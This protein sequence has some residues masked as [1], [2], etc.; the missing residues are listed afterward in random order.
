M[1]PQD[2]EAVISSLSDA[3]LACTGIDPEEM[4][5]APIGSTEEPTPA[6]VEE[7]AKLIGC[8]DD[9]TVNQFY[10]AAIVPC[11]GPLSMEAT[12]CILAGLEVIDPRALMTAGLVEDEPEKAAF[13]NM[14][15]SNVSIACLTDEDWERVGPASGMSDLDRAVGQCLMTELGGPGEYAETLIRT[16]QESDITKLVRAGEE[17]RVIISVPWQPPATPTPMPTATL[18]ATTPTPKPAIVAS[19]PTPPPPRHTST[20]TLPETNT[21]EITVAAI[22]EWL[23]EYDR[24]AIA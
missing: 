1:P 13:G 23:P 21:L 22:P 7:M 8:L 14:A 11:P 15:A 24:R 16:T 6:D 18:W 17:C 19:E 5:T 4:I 2:R 12:G 10:I 20:P 9:D 3:E